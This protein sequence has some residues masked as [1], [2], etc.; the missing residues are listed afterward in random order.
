MSK[1]IIAGN[2]KQ[3][4]S[5]KTSVKLSK[6]I[7]YALKKNNY[8]HEIIIFPPTL[9][10]HPIITNQKHEKLKLGSQNV[11]SFNNGAYTGEISASMLK[12]L[13]MNY[14]LVGHSE[15]RH[16]LNEEDAV[17]SDKVS[18]LY[19]NNLKVIY[20]I[21]ETLEQYK[22]KETKTILKNQIRALFKKNKLNIVSKPRNL[23]LAYEPVWAIGTGLIPTDK[24]LTNTFNFIYK[25]I[26]SLTNNKSSLKILYGGSVTPDNA[27]MLMK[28]KHMDGLLIG[29]ASL[30]AKK[31]IDICSTI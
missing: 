7:S 23:I 10:L 17:L 29:G 31:F 27:F 13:K 25:T 4:G 5:L 6:D 2:W 8:K 9:Y 20:C 12:D 19:E 11:S 22:N 21:G 3:N 15:R 30:N 26:N 28:T 16:I 14:C 24:E 1:K 18:R